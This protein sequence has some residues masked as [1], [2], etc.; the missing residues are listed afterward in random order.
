MLL[1]CSSFFHLFLAK[2]TLLFPLQL[3]L[4]YFLGEI[5]I[6]KPPKEY[7]PWRPFT[8]RMFLKIYASDSKR[9]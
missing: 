2:N 8:L 4:T 9:R 1:C 5:Q 3:I 6:E 7:F